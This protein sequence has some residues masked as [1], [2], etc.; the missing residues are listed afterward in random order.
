MV[1]LIQMVIYRLISLA[2]TIR[3]PVRQ[4]EENI[5]QGGVIK[6]LSG[7]VPD[8]LRCTHSPNIQGL[9]HN[10]IARCLSP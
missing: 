3:R 9:L 1:E 2:L 6:L 10:D 4:Y 8:S 5:R 7:V